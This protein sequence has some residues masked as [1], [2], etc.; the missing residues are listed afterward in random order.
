[1]AEH[2]ICSVEGCCNPI[3]GRGLCDKHLKRL[4]KH[5]DTETR[6]RAATGERRAWLE[7]HID[8]Q[9]EDCLAWPY[10]RYHTGFGQ[11][12]VSLGVNGTASRVMCELAHGPAPSSDHQAAHSCG[13]GH[14]GCVHPGHLRWATQA[15]NE[16]DK[17]V[18]GTHSRGER[19]WQAKLTEA[20]VRRIKSLRGLKSQ[21]ALAREYG[22]SQTTISDVM[23]GRRWGW[24]T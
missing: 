6:L 11:F 17:L 2:R 22:V 18:H 5:G 20:D 9:G 23:T 4:R 12:S 15:E 10:S 21:S 3:H 16:A 24:L 19:Q 1:M 7:A 8:Y 13:K 14:E